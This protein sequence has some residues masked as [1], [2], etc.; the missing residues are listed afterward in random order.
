M[1]GVGCMPP[2]VCMF[3]PL[4]QHAAAACMWLLSRAC[5]TAVWAPS[6]VAGLHKSVPSSACWHAAD[7]CPEA[8]AG[9]AHQ[10]AAE[11]RQRQSQPAECASPH[12][13]ATVCSPR[14]K[15]SSSCTCGGSLL[16][17]MR[18]RQMRQC[19]GH[20]HLS[21]G[22]AASARNPG[23]VGGC[24]WVCRQVHQR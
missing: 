12:T 9:G 21:L 17:R 22:R 7:H 16:T 5:S 4:L 13:R 10:E 1:H 2:G 24:A 23:G 3:R 14:V 6:T 8:A 15:S 19:C 18:G 20:M 11:R